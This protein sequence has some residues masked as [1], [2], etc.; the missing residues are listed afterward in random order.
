MASD[1]LTQMTRHTVLRKATTT[2]SMDATDVAPTLF[3]R[4]RRGPE[5]EPD[6]YK[7]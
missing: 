4:T 2:L 7:A 6:D 1:I 3:E 5:E